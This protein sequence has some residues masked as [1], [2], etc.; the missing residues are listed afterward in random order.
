M[1]A[2]ATPERGAE[3]ALSKAERRWQAAALTA[4]SE[5]AMGITCCPDMARVLLVEDYQGMRKLLCEAAEDAGHAIDC[6][7]TMREAEDLLSAGLYDLVICSV[8]LPDGSGVELAVRAAD[9]GMGTVVI[10]GQPDSLK[11]MTITGAT[12]LKKPFNV[13]EFRKL[14]N[15]HLGA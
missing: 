6:V 11:A 5:R 14:L 3:P 2:H 8:V 12:H 10:S 7:E 4:G 9:L 13:E 15:D 1:M